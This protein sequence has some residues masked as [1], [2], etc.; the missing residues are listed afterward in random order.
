MKIILRT[1]VLQTRKR[2]I[3]KNKGVRL[4]QNEETET[5]SER[6]SMTKWNGFVKKTMNGVEDGQTQVI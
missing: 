1:H 3:G 2:V 4:K 6:K 5:K